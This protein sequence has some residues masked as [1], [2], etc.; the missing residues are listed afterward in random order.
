[1]FR[2]KPNIFIFPDLS[3]ANISYKIIQRI[4]NFSVVGPLIWGLK[5]QVSDL[6][7][8]ATSEEIYRTTLLTVWAE[9]LRR[10]NKVTFEENMI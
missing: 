2:G 3:S 1:L 8:G 10:K 4:G 5:Q 6:S 7:R 9:I